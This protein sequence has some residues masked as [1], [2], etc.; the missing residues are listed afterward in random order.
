[1]FLITSPYQQFFDLDGGPLDGGRV[2]F[3]SVGTNPLIPA[4]QVPIF[5]DAAGTQPAAQPIMTSNGY[6]HRSGTPSA[7]FSDAAYSMAVYSNRGELVAYSKDAQSGSGFSIGVDLADPSK[8]A[9]MVA[10]MRDAG[11][12]VSRTVS[13]KI[14]EVVSVKDFGAI[15]DGVTNDTAAIEKAIAASN[16]VFFPEGDYLYDGISIN[17]NNF[18]MY[19]DGYARARLVM[20]PSANIAISVADS[21]TVSG[22]SISGILLQG[23]SANTGGIKLG[24]NGL[25][26]AT[27]LRFRDLFIDGFSN[28]SD[29]KGY[30]IQF[31]QN[32]NTDLVNIW[33]QNN[34]VGLHRANGG[35]C[36]STRISGKD[37]YLGRSDYGVLIEGQCDDFYIE[38]GV[39]EGNRGAGIIVTQD[40]A[41]TTGVGRGT[42]LVV[43]KAYFEENNKAGL[44]E[45]AG[46]VVKGNSFGL[47]QHILDLTASQFAS[48]PSNPSTKDVHLDRAFAYIA[49]SRLIPGNVQ[50][51]ATCS[52]RF[53]NLTY[54]NSANY[55]TQY[56]ALLGNISVNDFTAAFS[57]ADLNQF[58]Y[59]NAITF[60]ATSR[61]VSDP[62]TLDDYR[63]GTWTPVLSSDGVAPTI[64]YTEQVGTITKIGNLVFVKAQ[65]RGILSAA[66]TGTPRI[67]GFPS[68]APAG[69]EP[70]NIS[71][72]SLISAAPA[73]AYM[74]AGP[75]LILN[76]V[77]Y[78]VSA[79]N[80]YIVATVVY[81]TPD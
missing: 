14:S 20:T 66:G 40:A 74:I 37:T 27:K 69:L 41:T 57:G 72:R 2:Y 53:E 44:S 6:M 34:R 71:L 50:T 8:G 39:V 19:S 31:C 10:W 26:A 63:E 46:V 51:T 17:K 79:G 16:T 38:D 58:N 42:R 23:N 78:A 68:F 25:H 59:H 29:Q 73:S 60:P 18:T 3:G 13:E 61:P 33:T 12:A 47:A 70:A 5:W 22:L 52:V 75:A 24:V 55:S 4:N 36:T 62:N 11:G 56:K 64:S 9:S 48:N 76:G 30:A 54:P 45:A 65:I 15:G 7:V 35:Y 67:T 43:G 28:T 49:R 32:Q 1:M 77:T 21:S 80:N 81:Q